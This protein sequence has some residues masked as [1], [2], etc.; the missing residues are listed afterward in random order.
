VDEWLKL[1]PDLSVKKQKTTET[2]GKKSV[3]EVLFCKYCSYEVN[4]NN[5]PSDLIRVHMNTDKHKRLKESQLKRQESGKQL[6]LA[7]TVCRSKEREKTA[8][9]FIHDF[10]RAACFDAIPLLKADT[11][12]GKLMKKYVPSAK[13]L[14]QAH[15]IRDKYL[16][17][18]YDSH[19]NAI[20]S[21]IGN[22]K[23][24]LIIDESPDMKGRPVLNILISFF[25]SEI[26]YK[27]VLLIKTII[28]VNTKSAT[29]LTTLLEVLEEFGL[30][31]DN[32]L[33]ICSDSAEYMRKL[34]SD[35]KCNY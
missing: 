2:N 7:E 35:I 15:Q 3:E 23:L 11:Y 14:P 28:I 12:L 4:M 13:S 20:K 31:F 33:A 9:G 5:R 10:V 27:R 19:I 17:E 16:P 25:D 18:V 22:K 8:E 32:I 26:N 1:Y 24:S 6:T 34:V 29:I 30:T 21:K